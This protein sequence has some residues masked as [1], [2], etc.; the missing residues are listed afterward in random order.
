MQKYTF[1]FILANFK[2]K[3]KLSSS[4]IL[5]SLNSASFLPGIRQHFSIKLRR[6]PTMQAFTSFV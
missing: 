3:T 1:L 4:F 2:R 6:K 5:F